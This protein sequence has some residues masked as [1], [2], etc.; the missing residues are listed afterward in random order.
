[1]L[2]GDP[3][4]MSTTR[5][6]VPR[7]NTAKSQI[8]RPVRLGDEV[9]GLLYAQLMG[10]TIKPGSRISIDN[11]AR[12]LGVSQTPIREALS[13]LEA[14]GLVVKTHLI[15]YRAS[16]QLDR[17]RL[18][19]LYT[20]RLLLEPYAARH[21]AMRM[22]KA[23]RLSLDELAAQMDA[24]RAD[25]DA[26]A[27]LDEAFHDLIAQAGGNELIQETLARLHIHVHLF[28]LFRPAQATSGAMEEHAEIL[29]GLHAGDGDA[30]ETAMHRHIERS[31]KR[32][33]S[34][35][36]FDHAP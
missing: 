20:L 32:F 31:H 22:T 7:P 17:E 13:R 1:M 2:S 8:R 30:A 5:R 36:E 9:Y 14:E 12:E 4:K 16:E 35:F 19:Q 3:S 11:L 23:Q 15:G 26:F 27:R 6:M 28:R 10:R 34:G 25:Y 24:A 18:D 29:T 33:R 21:A